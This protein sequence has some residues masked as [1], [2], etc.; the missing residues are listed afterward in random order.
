MSHD[1]SVRIRIHQLEDRLFSV[2]VR[3]LSQLQGQGVYAP[4]D[5]ATGLVCDRDCEIDS[6][7]EVAFL[8]CAHGSAAVLT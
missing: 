7:G 1:P 8:A 5:D 2:S 6:V 3:A 4:V